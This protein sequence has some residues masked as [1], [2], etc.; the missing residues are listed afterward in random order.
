MR[1]CR[2]VDRKDDGVI[3]ADELDTTLKNL[4]IRCGHCMLTV[5]PKMFCVSGAS[6]VSNA[7]MKDLGPGHRSWGSL[8]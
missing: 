7:M 5:V 8:Q 3:S 6:D 1:A 4:G 2:Y